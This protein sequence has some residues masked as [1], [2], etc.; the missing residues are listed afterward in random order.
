MT[1]DRV[2]QAE[3]PEARLARL[4]SEEVYWRYRRG[5]LESCGYTLLPR[6]RPDWSPSWRGKARGAV[7]S[8]EDGYSLPF[9]SS[10]IDAMRMSDGW[11]PCVHQEGRK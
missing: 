6:Y 5:F 10:V 8:A 11:E 2:R 3:R 1:T 9:R 7:F 4:S